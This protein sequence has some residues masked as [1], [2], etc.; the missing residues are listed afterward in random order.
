M[1]AKMNWGGNYGINSKVRQ[2]LFQMPCAHCHDYYE[3]YYLVSGERK[4]FI[5]DSVYYMQ[6]GDAV[7][8]HKNDLHKTTFLEKGKHERIVITF[9]EAFLSGFANRLEDGALT[10]KKIRFQQGERAY[11]EQLL[12]R[13]I[14][15]KE[16]DDQ[17]GEYL[18]R[19][20]IYEVILCLLRCAAEYKG[21]NAFDEILVNDI[22]KEIQKAAKYIYHHYD[23]PLT[24]RGMAG[25]AGMSQQYFSKRFKRVTGFGFKEY[26]TMLRI[27]HSKELLQD[28]H[29]SVTQIGI[30]CGFSDGNYFGDAFRK[31]V[32]MSPVQYRSEK[33]QGPK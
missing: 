9:D 24:L 17:Y 31:A 4:I 27:N 14:K 10:S 12:V 32:G 13:A 15:E 5:K 33:F 30:R 22:E 8:I 26:L 20:H 28:S 18:C 23:Q 19:L 25:I 16:A 7:I 3:L 2:T 6:P 11:L 21:Q 1:K 29:L